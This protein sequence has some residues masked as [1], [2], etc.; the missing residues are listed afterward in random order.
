MAYLESDRVAIREYLGFASLFLQAD[1]RLE[2]AI[3]ASQSVAD[4]GTRPTSDTEM[5]AKA[6]VTKLQAV[7]AAIDALIPAMGTGSVDEVK[8]DTARE[9]ARLRADGRRWVHR[10]ARIFDTYPRSDVYSSAPELEEEY[11]GYPRTA[12]RRWG[13]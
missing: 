13:Y 12:G 5:R 8:L 3:T 7:D 6:I 9:D 1:P 4:G 10:L 11:P 2:S